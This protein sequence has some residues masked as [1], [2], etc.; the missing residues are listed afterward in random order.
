[1][2]ARAA[3][4]VHHYPWALAWLLSVF[5]LVLLVLLIGDTT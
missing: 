3:R 5:L 4:V 1:V 2:K